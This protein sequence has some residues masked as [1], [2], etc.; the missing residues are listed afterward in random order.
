MEK[1][2]LRG[3]NLT[4]WLMLES[5]VSPEIF[6]GTGTFNEKELVKVL[7]VEEYLKQ[8]KEHRLTFITKEDFKNIASRGFNAVRIPIPWYVFGQ[9]GPMPGLHEGCLCN[10]DD[11]FDWAD[12]YGLNILLDL[13]LVPGAKI[14][15]DG[16]QIVLDTKIDF[17]GAALE[18]VARLVDRYKD[19]KSFWGIEPIGEVHAQKRQGF[20]LTSGTPLHVLRNFYR[21][22]Y[23]VVREIAGDRI[24]VVISD[25]GLHGS[26]RMFM[27][28]R[29]YTN[30]WLDV[31]P[32]RFKDKA[33]LK[34]SSG[35]RLLIYKIL[36]DLKEA[37]RSG[38]PVMV[39]E[40]S[41]ALPIADANMT[42]EGRIAMERMYVAGQLEAFEK[43]QG[44]FF[45]TWKT[46]TGLSSWDARIALSSFERDML[47]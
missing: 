9:D 6:A 42:P 7:G 12:E 13:T 43:C 20:S 15:P 5:W 39:G 29:K 1:Q 37:K 34:G 21:D 46:S 23:D 22:A 32:Y 4:G 8:L 26:W 33:C 47:D 17:R 35:T 2:T 10:L 45:Q 16:L 3:V 36:D 25:A 30:V 24:Y 31:H 28:H 18:V 14:T 19:R 40:W 41:A 27:A 11:A 38:F 44:W